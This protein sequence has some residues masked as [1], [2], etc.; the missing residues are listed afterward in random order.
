MVILLREKER[1]ERRKERER[2]E[3]ELYLSEWV[4]KTELGKKVKN[5]EITSLDEIFAKNTPI[6]EPEI[7]DLLVDLE[8]EILEV[9]KTSRVVRAGRKFAFRAAVLVGNK[10]GLVGIGSAKDTDKWPAI[11][12]AKKKARLNL[13]RVRRGCGSWECTCNEQHSVPFRVEGKCASVRVTLLSA[14]NGVGLVAGDN[15]KKVLEFAGIRDVWSK[16]S[17]ATKTTLNFALATINALSKTSKMRASNEITK[18]F[19]KSK[20]E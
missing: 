17:G 16:T 18:K 13:V 14:P 19:S 4:P 1:A 10:N 5:S 12:K 11:E 15:I 3:K 7:V 9:R 20:K 6:L 8:E 2:N